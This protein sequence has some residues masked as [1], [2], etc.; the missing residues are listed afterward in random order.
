MIMNQSSE[1]TEDQMFGNSS[2]TESSDP[3]QI[4]NASFFDTSNKSSSIEWNS[5]FNFSPHVQLY[6]QI[7]RFYSQNE[8]Q[9]WSYLFKNALQQTDDPFVLLYMFLDHTID[10]S[11][12]KKHKL[13]LPLI[14]Q[15]KQVIFNNQ[16]P[17]VLDDRIKLNI[18]NKICRRCIFS[19]LEGIIDVFQL[20]SIENRTLVTNFIEKHIEKHQDIV[21]ISQMVKILGLLQSESIP[22]EKII[23]PLI[24]RTQWDTVRFVIGDNKQFQHKLLKTID[25]LISSDKNVVRRLLAQSS[26]NINATYLDT[27]SLKRA[28]RKLLKLYNISLDEL[29]NL[30]TQEKITFLKTLFVRKYIEKRTTGDQNEDDQSWDEQIRDL[31]QNNHEVQVKLVDLFVDYTDLDAA[32]QWAHIYQLEDFDIPEQV[33]RRRE[34][35]IVNNLSPQPFQSQSL[36]PQT[37]DFHYKPTVN[38]SDIIYIEVDGEVDPFLDRLECSR[39]DVG[40]HLPFVGFDCETFMDPT[41]RTL[42]TQIVSIIQL[43]T[44]HPSRDQ[45]FYGVFDM[46]AL[47]LQLD[48]K[49]FSEFAQR[50]FCSKDFILLTYNYACDTSSLIENYPSMSDALTQGSAVIDLFHIQNYILENCPEIFPFRQDS[51]TIKSR[52]LSELVRLCFGKPLDKSLQISD[53]RKRPLKPAQLIYSVLDARVLVDIAQFIEERTR[54]L[55]ITWSWSDFKGYRWTNKALKKRTLNNHP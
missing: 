54:T 26:V 38:Q 5:P 20:N 29:P 43:A 28:E 49:A 9:Q 51:K 25:C 19:Q 44:F 30:V 12:A 36:I 23:V 21:F 1:E 18:L 15:F 48:M 22:F 46:L 42:N 41:Q 32:V 11:N 35:L 40:S 8:H 31:S 17:I 47:R 27:R 33:R 34:E 13:V 45:I 7:Y 39:C 16:Q 52:G 2:T 4:V 14:E 3:E 24:L 55:A 50:L 37:E 6:E 10:T 53:W